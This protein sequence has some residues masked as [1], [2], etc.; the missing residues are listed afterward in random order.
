MKVDAQ[1]YADASLAGAFPHI[2]FEDV[3]SNNVSCSQN[4]P[5]A[6]RHVPEAMPPR[7]TDDQIL[8]LTR[9]IQPAV[10]EASFAD[11]FSKEYTAHMNAPDNLARA[12]P[13]YME[14]QKRSNLLFLRIFLTRTAHT[15]LENA[16]AALTHGVIFLSI[17]TARMMRM[18]RG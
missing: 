3:L 2:N 18:L 7:V 9:D 11:V 4:M 13:L 17:E 12:F 6:P 15:S 10:Y 16:L 14:S 1:T 5:V 8:P